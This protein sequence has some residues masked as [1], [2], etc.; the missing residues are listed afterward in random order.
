MGLG[1]PSTPPPPHRGLRKSPPGR[2]PL[3]SHTAPGGTPRPSSRA[4]GGGPRPAGGPPRACQG[5]AAPHGV[6]PRTPTPGER[7]GSRHP[8]Q[9]GQRPGAV[10]EPTP[11]QE[12]AQRREASRTPRRG[13]R[14]RPRAPHLPLPAAA[15]RCP[16]PKMA[17][18]APPSLR[19][20]PITAEP[21]TRMPRPRPAAAAHAPPRV[22]GARAGM[23]VRRRRWA[24]A[25]G[26]VPRGACREL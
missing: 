16:A 23:G 17:A 21:P 7:R 20:P 24:G 6:G 8:R 11:P 15:A 1:S 9:L 19:A 4:A 2:A 3:P 14:G 26:R 5:R 12:A 18:A 22:G 10:A 13:G 25:G